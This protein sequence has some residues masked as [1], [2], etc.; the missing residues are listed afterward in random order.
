MTA[1]RALVFDFTAMASPCSIAIEGRDERAMKRAADSAIGEVKRI[2][3]KFSRYLAASVV[4]RIN[5]AAGGAP[6]AVDDETA[7]LLDFAGELWR[8]SQGRFDVTSGVLRQAWDFRRAQLPAQAHV[9]ALLQLVGW[10]QVEWDPRARR[11]RLPRA[12]MEIDFGG[13]GKEYA[14]DRAAAVLRQHG[15]EHAIVNLG[16]DVHV[17]GPHGVPDARGEPWRIAIEHPRPGRPG[18]L[19]A[20]VRVLQG[21]VATSGDYERWFEFEGRR[22]CHILDPRTG[23]PVRDWQS[24]SVIAGNTTSAGALSTIAMLRSDAIEWLQAQAVRFIA[25]DADGRVASHGGTAPDGASPSRD[26]HAG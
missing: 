21:G 24:V 2:E 26:P 11:I 6:V 14:A 22:Y 4:S 20:T 16:G 3:S 1:W 7:S 5:A 23:W 15:L 10:P 19:L 9:D 25:V 18:E 12:G 13:F 8:Q 17:L